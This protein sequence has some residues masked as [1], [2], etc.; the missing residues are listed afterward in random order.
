[1]TF[2]VSILRTGC[3]FKAAWIAATNLSIKSFSSSDLIS[4]GG[5]SRSTSEPLWGS[6]GHESVPVVPVDLQFH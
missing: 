6:P 5:G 3:P 4:L 2:A 1:M